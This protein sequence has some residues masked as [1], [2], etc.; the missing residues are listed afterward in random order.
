[1]DLLNKGCPE[2]GISGAETSS[3]PQYCI[4]YNIGVV[5]DSS[6]DVTNLGESY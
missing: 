2:D 4:E 3:H 1:L 5:F 6:V